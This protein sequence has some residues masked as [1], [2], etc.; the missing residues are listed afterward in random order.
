MLITSDPLVL[1]SSGPAVLHDFL[2]THR[3]FTAG[4]IDLL[5]CLKA[6]DAT[7]TADDSRVIRIKYE[8]AV[9]I[10]W[11]QGVQHSQNLD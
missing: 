5:N 9:L 7:A 4:G 10:L 11:P 8:L 3:S 6:R 1:T 2:L